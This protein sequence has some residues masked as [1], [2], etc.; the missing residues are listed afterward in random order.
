MIVDVFT[1]KRTDAVNL[2]NLERRQVAFAAN[3]FSLRIQILQGEQKLQ[4]GELAIFGLRVFRLVL[5][6]FECVG[7]FFLGVHNERSAR[8]AH[9][10]CKHL[11]VNLE[12]CKMF[13]DVLCRF[14]VEQDAVATVIRGTRQRPRGPCV[15]N[16]HFFGIQL[17]AGE[18][19]AG[20][21]DLPLPAKLK[22]QKRI[23]FKRCM[24]A[25]DFM[26]P[27]DSVDV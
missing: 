22:N 2:F 14:L 20:P 19:L 24:V 7:H 10:L 13:V 8:T 21:T 11:D 4:N 26:Q 6:F 16:Q 18:G 25:S 5:D 27:F 15:V 3:G 12:P 23:P 17:I 1:D 9:L